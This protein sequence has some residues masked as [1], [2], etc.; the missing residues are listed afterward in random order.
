MNIQ[1]VGRREGGDTCLMKDSRKRGFTRS[2]SRISHSASE[3]HKTALGGAP[4]MALSLSPQ[5]LD[6]GFVLP[7]KVYKQSITITNTLNTPITAATAGANLQ[8]YTLSQQN[9][10]LQPRQA[11]Q[12]IV[13]LKLDKLPPRRLEKKSTTHK[14][15]FLVRTAQGIHRFTATFSCGDTLS[16]P[17]SRDISN[18]AN[19]RMKPQQNASTIQVNNE[20]K[21][22]KVDVLEAVPENEVMLRPADSCDQEGEEI[23][24]RQSPEKPSTEKTWFGADGME[25]LLGDIN[26]LYPS[27][28][29]HASEVDAA[30]EAA[31]REISA[32]TAHSLQFA[33][34]LDHCPFDPLTVQ[35]LIFHMH[36]ISNRWLL[37]GILPDC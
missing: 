27:D 32:A 35:R 17:G 34:Q 5:A 16:T 25:D 21:Y 37:A 36:Q 29:D 2:C 23:V 3:S 7:D 20:S 31:T 8:R 24:R 22:S 4:A 6:F 30:S 33:S 14:D 13:S 10:T 19:A 11:L 18:E 12:L 28:V 15:S 26:M 1:K 9:F